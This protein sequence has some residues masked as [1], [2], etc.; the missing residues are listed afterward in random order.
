MGTYANSELEAIHE[1]MPDQYR[2][3]EEGVDESFY[4][5]VATP[6]LDGIVI[7]PSAL[8]DAFTLTARDVDVDLDSVDHYSLQ[9]AIG[10][11]RL[12]SYIDGDWHFQD[13]LTYDD[14]LQLIDEAVEQGFDVAYCDNLDFVIGKIRER[15]DNPQDPQEGMRLHK[16]DQL[17]EAMMEELPEVLDSLSIQEGMENAYQRISAQE[18]DPQEIGRQLGQREDDIIRE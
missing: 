6:Q 16:F 9:Q 5:R 7:D 3:Q 12:D 4:R 17:H 8:V 18:D 1:Q 10:E 13:L 11:Q 14:T 15:I 2:F